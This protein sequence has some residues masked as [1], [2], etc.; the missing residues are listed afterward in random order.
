MADKCCS[1]QE[2]IVPATTSRCSSSNDKITITT[3][4]CCSYNKAENETSNCCSGEVEKQQ[5]NTSS[6]INEKLE[7]RIHGM[8]CPSC[9]LTIERGLRGLEN[10]QE[11]KVNYNTA[12]LQVVG[13]NVLSLGNVENQVQNLGFKI[14]RLNQNKDFRTYDVVGMDCGS[15]AKSIEKHLS[16]IS[17]VN[18][19]T[20][21]F[22]TGKMKV[23][24]EN[25][26]DEIVSEVSKLGF[27]AT[28][29][30]DSNKTTETLKSKKNRDMV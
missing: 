16:K 25:S 19:V 10:I 7:F 24:H 28:L 1:S 30:T 12:K 5:L 26:A 20:V 17:T 6:L 15:C 9:A 21:S 14:E 3:I 27:K 23:E 8:D 29:L 2:N 22:S 18:K 13:N 4:S 11:A